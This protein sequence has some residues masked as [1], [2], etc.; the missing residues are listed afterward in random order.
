MMVVEAGKQQT[1]H[2]G[3]LGDVCAPTPAA[4]LLWEE[5]H[6]LQ[7]PLFKKQGKKHR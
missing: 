3:A 7:G 2:A 6:N 1:L 4:S 5:K